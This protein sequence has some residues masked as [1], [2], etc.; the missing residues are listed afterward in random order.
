MLIIQK[1]KKL[2]IGEFFKEQS[3]CIWLENVLL[4]KWKL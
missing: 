2:E 1:E 3:N 4:T